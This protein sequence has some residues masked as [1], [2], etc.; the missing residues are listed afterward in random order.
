MGNVLLGFSHERMA[1]Q[2]AAVAGI[3][4][5]RSWQIVFEQDLNE[6]F[7]RG[8]LTPDQFFDE[9]S[10]A[11]GSRPDR[12]A[13]EAAANDIFWVLPQM[14]SLV[15][16]LYAAGHKLGLLSNTNACHWQFV[17]QQYGC[18]RTMFHVRLASFEARSLKPQP[19][20]YLEA[21]RR[22]G[23]SP[24]DVFFTDDRQENVDGAKKAGFDAVLFTTAPNLARELMRRGIGG[25]Y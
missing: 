19:Q 10:A 16:H 22:A 25:N 1:S 18:I 8:D 7:E 9:Y 12:A 23:V 17:Q 21:A 6:R 5:E 3:P 11:A 4:Y 13:L 2:M 14:A 24:A 15:G 20:I